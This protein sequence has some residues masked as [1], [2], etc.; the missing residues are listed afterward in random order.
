MIEQKRRWEFSRLPHAKGNRIYTPFSQLIDQYLNSMI[1]NQPE[2]DASVGL[3]C[4]L[5]V[6][7]GCADGFAPEGMRTR[8]ND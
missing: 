1:I 6:L 4:L 8:E 5:A 3:P 7:R 2:R